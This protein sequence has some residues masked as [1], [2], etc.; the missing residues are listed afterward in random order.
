M[1]KNR[2]R[3]NEPVSGSIQIIYTSDVMGEE[4]TRRFTVTFHEKGKTLTLQDGVIRELG[5]ETNYNQ[6]YEY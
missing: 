4:F 2:K 5:P 1:C 6:I 3:K